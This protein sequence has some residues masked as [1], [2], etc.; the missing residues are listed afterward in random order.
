MT[1]INFWV[2]VE[3]KINFE[4]YKKNKIKF[5]WRQVI[6]WNIN[7]CVM[8]ALHAQRSKKAEKHRKSTYEC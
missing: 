4:K 7:K 6:R 1:F 2:V 5:H 8:L 3:H